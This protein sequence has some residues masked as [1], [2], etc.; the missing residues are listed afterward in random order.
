M[1]HDDEDNKLMT[2]VFDT[3]DMKDKAT[4]P[5]NSSC[6]GPSGLGEGSPS[7]ARIPC[8]IDRLVEVFPDADRATLV[9]VAKVSSSID[10]A[11]E[12]VLT[13]Q[14]NLVSDVKEDTKGTVL[15]SS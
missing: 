9:D 5:S 6:A 12:N 14:T 1:I 10:E 8:M 15:Y 4:C 11:V 13:R 7:T 2:S 3:P